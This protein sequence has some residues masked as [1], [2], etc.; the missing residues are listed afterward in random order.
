MKWI[1]IVVFIH[2]GNQPMVVMHDF[3][4]QPACEAAALR[5]KELYVE[6]R[7]KLQAATACVQDPPK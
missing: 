4:S 2:S 3:Q 6:I 1:L 5:T 7:G